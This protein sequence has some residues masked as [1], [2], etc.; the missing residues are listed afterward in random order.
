MAGYSGHSFERGSWPGGLFL[1]DCTSVPSLCCIVWE[2]DIHCI[3]EMLSFGEAAGCFGLGP[4]KIASSDKSWLYCKS[5]HP[6]IV[7]YF[8]VC[9][10]NTQ[11][12]SLQDGMHMLDCMTGLICAMYGLL[13]CPRRCI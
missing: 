7:L 9:L 10:Y 6:S 8:Y 11:L 12:L 2:E 4:R 5:M 3:T 13:W 1:E